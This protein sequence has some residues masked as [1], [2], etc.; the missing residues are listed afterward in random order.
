MDFSQGSLVYF[1]SETASRSDHFRKASFLRRLQQ[2]RGPL[3][4]CEERFAHFSSG[5][6]SDVEPDRLIGN[7]GELCELPL[8]SIFGSAVFRGCMPSLRVILG[9]GSVA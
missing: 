9:F 5:R 6:V 4:I 2:L 3:F 1:S 7:F 8:S